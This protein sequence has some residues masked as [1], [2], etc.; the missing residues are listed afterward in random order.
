MKNLNALFILFL[1]FFFGFS[2]NSYSQVSIPYSN[3]FDGVND[4][5][6]WTHYSIDGT[7]DWEWG[8]PNDSPFGGAHSYFNAWVTNLDGDLADS[9]SRALETPYFDLS[10]TSVEYELSFFQK[11]LAYWSVEYYMEYFIENIGAWTLLDISTS[12]KKNWQTVNGFTGFA[13]SIFEESSISLSELQGSGNVKFRFKIVTENSSSN[14][15]M[16][17]DFSIKEAYNNIYAFPAD[18]INISNECSEITVNSSLGIITPNYNS[19]VLNLTHYFFS[20]DTIIDNQDVFL[21]EKSSYISFFGGGTVLDYW[22]HTMDFT[23]NLAVGTYYILYHH[24]AVDSI[25]EID[26]LDNIGYAVLNIDSIYTPNYV[27]DFESGNP[28]YRTYNKNKEAP[29][30]WSQGQGYRHHLEGTHSGENAWHTSKTFE[31]ENLG[32]G[33]SCE[34]FVEMPYFNLSGNSENLVLNLWYKNDANGLYNV[35]QYNDNCAAG[36]TNYDQI[37]SCR[38]DDWDFYNISL[39]DLSDLENVKFRFKMSGNY[40]DRE[41]MNFDDIYLGPVKPDL[42]IESDKKNH[43]GNS[44]NTEETLHYYL[45]NSGLMETSVTST[46]FYWSVDSIFDASDI[47]LGVKSEVPLFDTSKVWT[48]F[49]FSKPTTAA[50]KYYIFYELDASDAIDEMREY[51]NVGHFIFYQNT[52]ASYPYYNDFETEIDGWRHAAYLGEDDWY[53]KIPDGSSLGSAFSGEKAWVVRKDENNPPSSRMILNT[54]IYDLSN[55]VKPVIEF[56]M[57]LNGYSNCYCFRHEMNM[58]YSTDGGATWEVLDTTSQSYNR[59]YNRVEYST[60]GGVDGIDSYSG[61]TKL[62]FDSAEPLFI[63]SSQSYGYNGRDADRNTRYILDVNSLAGQEQVQFRFNMG[64]TYESEIDTFNINETVL[65][66]NFSIKEGQTDLIVNYKKDLMIS[67]NSDEVNFFMKIK[68]EGNYFSQPGV[69]KFYLSADTLLDASDYLLGTDTIPL[70]RPDLSFYVNVMLEAPSDLE[71]YTYLIYEL[72][73]DNTTTETNED[74]NISYW[75]LAMEGVS[76]FPYYEDFEEKHINGWNHY[77]YLGS[78]HQKNSFRFRNQTAP[79]E[80]LYQTEIKSGEMFTDRV[81]GTSPKPLW[82]LETPRF[83]FSGLDSIFLSF[84]LFCYG[85]TYPNVDGGNMEFSIDGGNTWTLLDNSYGDNHNWYPYVFS[86]DFGGER[87]WRRGVGAYYAPI[88][89]DSTSF[90]LSFLKGESD[91]VFRYKYKSNGGTAYVN[92]Q[93][94]RIDNFKIETYSLD[95][96]AQDSMEVINVDLN[97]QS[98]L[99]IDYTIANEGNIDGGATITKVFWSE[100]AVLDSNDLVK[101]IVEQDPISAGNSINTSTTFFVPLLNTQSVYYVFYQTDANDILS[102][103]NEGNNVG[104]FKVFLTLPTCPTYIVFETQAEVDSFPVIYPNCT[105]IPETVTITGTVNNLDSLIQLT[106]IGGNLQIQGCEELETLIGLENLTNVGAE[107]FIVENSN[108]IYLNGL[109][110]LTNVG[111]GAQIYRNYKLSSLNGLNNLETVGNSFYIGNMDTMI[112]G[113]PPFSDLSG[114]ESLANV[115]GG[116]LLYDLDYLTNLSG[117]E[118]LN[119][120]GTSLT[121]ENNKR[122]KSLE[123]LEWITSFGT[124]LIITSNDSLTSLVG[125]EN[126]ESIDGDFNLIGNFQLDDLS[127]LSNLTSIEDVLRIFGSYGLPSLDGFSNLTNVEEIKLQDNPLLTSL[128]GLENVNTT[129]LTNL[130]ID[131][132]PLLAICNEPNI[133][134]YLSN[135]GTSTVYNNA[136]GC[137][138]PSEIEVSCGNNSGNDCPDEIQGFTTLGEFGNSKYYLSNTPAQPFAAQDLAASFGGH[139]TTISSQEENDFIQQNISDMVYLGLNDFDLEGDLVWENGEPLNYNNINPCGFCNENS[140]DQDFVVMQPWDGAWSFSSVWNSRKFIMEIP[141]GGTPVSEISIDCP[142][143]INVTLT[144]GATSIAIDFPNPIASTTCIGGEVIIEQISGA[145][146]GTTFEAGTYNITFEVTDTCGNIE[147]CTFI[148]TVESEIIPGDCPEEIVGFTTLG[149]FGNSK[150]YLSNDISR[151]TDAQVIAITHGGYLA[152]ISSQEENDFIQQGISEMV[153]IGLNDYDSEGNLEWFNSEPITFDNINPCGFC[154]E[155]SADQDFVIM[156]PWNGAWSFSN[157]FNSRKYVMEIPCG[158]NT[159]SLITVNCPAEQMIEL[160]VGENEVIIIYDE[161]TATTTCPDGGLT[162][163]LTSGPAIGEVQPIGKYT[164]IYTIT[165]ACGNSTQCL[166]IVDVVP[167]SNDSGCPNSLADFT[168]MGEFGNSAYFISDGDSRPTDAQAV[169]VANG[170]NLAVINSIEENNFIAGQINGLVYIGLDDYQSEGNPTWVDGSG[171]T[172][173]NFDICNFCNENSEEMDF[174][175]M[176]S[177][178]GA[179]SWSNFYNSRKYI[180]E[181]PCS[182]TL[183][184]PNNNFSLVVPLSEEARKPSLTKLVPNPAM[185]FIFVEIN[186]SQEQEVDLMIFD[187]RGSLVK[188]QTTNLLNGINAPMIDIAEL[189]AGFYSIYVPQAKTKFATER[190]VKVR[191]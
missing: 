42:S 46:N 140:A 45:N 49:D 63:N 29:S 159:T 102:E 154:N 153:Y 50:G 106:S 34:S 92:A 178:N 78:W 93:G 124:N 52:L 160:A 30:L 20:T 7:D 182:A 151:A 38:E 79:A 10:D 14:G 33:N 188:T 141:C 156:A 145:T 167:N 127:D 22:N 163:E 181:I 108:L 98:T 148:I 131:T 130:Q 32:C 120:I 101:Q 36:W 80:L 107:F 143:D 157:F 68:N 60:W 47:L 73:A 26:E 18:T 85:R 71:N 8:I 28:P 158:G 186:S 41:G 55:A 162:I 109:E 96:V 23:P 37:P 5:I 61:I 88:T 24:D 51:N 17:D 1:F 114:L 72:D 54:P 2:M 77:V 40:L 91:V 6:G 82:Y 185:D 56:D 191:D 110:G 155:N 67:P 135:G 183:N 123:G 146:S 90:D 103:S 104:S 147:N 99:T 12:D 100:D 64:V 133:C 134:D 171:N 19:S 112:V 15:W 179:W 21:G 174:V 74:N 95:Y 53:W 65:L 4:T 180:V 128:L 75:N 16:I 70:I 86:L 184:N 144:D 3:N 169:A 31:I 170:G 58:S 35:F 119:N 142:D 132:H 129:N 105:E 9:S 94:M 164:I 138:S 89:L 136:P 111:Q 83:D 122:L 125:L 176:H 113:Y 121:I 62:L 168:F 39:N 173:T 172:F 137:N 84:D 118:N 13:Y 117:F 189:P 66:D 139:L 43:F 48:S 149:E 44:S 161:V 11:R 166:F 97:N 177:W 69:T 25:Q 81:N 165:D 190:F 187:A 27:E 87:V 175:V 152:S 116:F 150:Y 57:M 59:W 115:G 126:L 76:Q